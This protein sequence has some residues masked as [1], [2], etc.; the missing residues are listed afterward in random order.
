MLNF[1]LFDSLKYSLFRPNFSHFIKTT[2]LHSNSTLEQFEGK[3]KKQQK[4]FVLSQL[5]YRVIF[6]DSF[7]AI[8]KHISLDYKTKAICT[9][10]GPEEAEAE[11]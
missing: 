4:T 1:W 8:C 6:W 7:I 10:H 5:M 9:T 2:E 11:S 3:K